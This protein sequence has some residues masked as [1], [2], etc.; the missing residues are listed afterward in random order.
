[1][2]KGKGSER[3]HRNTE[4][5]QLLHSFPLQTKPLHISTHVLKQHLKLCVHLPSHLIENTTSQRYDAI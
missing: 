4:D 5:Q 3:K 2:P 1:M